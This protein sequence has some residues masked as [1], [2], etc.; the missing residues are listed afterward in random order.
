MTFLTL[1]GHSEA[2]DTMALPLEEHRDNSG[3]ESGSPMPENGGKYHHTKGG[4]NSRGVQMKLDV[5]SASEITS[6]VDERVQGVA[7]HT[8]IRTSASQSCEIEEIEAFYA[9]TGETPPF[10][11]LT[12]YEKLLHNAEREILCA[13]HIVCCTCA[14]SATSRLRSAVTVSL[15]VVHDADEISEPEALLP[16]VGAKNALLL[17]RKN[18]TSRVLCASNIGETLFD[19]HEDR[20]IFLR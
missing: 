18:F 17:G 9:L 12:H 6:K 19:V 8:L 15:C 11:V 2:L 1:H 20:C 4:L 3:R 14:E 7:L 5:L 16:L 13:A 10:D